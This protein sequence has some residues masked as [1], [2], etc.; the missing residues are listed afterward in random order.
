MSLK[1]IAP[2]AWF[3]LEYP[4][5]WHEFEDTE[6]S[7][8]FYNP[9]KWSG[10]FRISAYRGE[11]S[12]YAPDCMK[13]E[14][15]CVPGAKVVK[16]DSWECV[17]SSESFQ[18]NGSWYTTHIWLTGEGE[19]SVECSFTV[20]KGE[21]VR[22]AEQI[23]ASLCIRKKD[24]APLHEIIPV[25]VLEINAINEGFDWAVS[26][27]KKSLT[28]DFTS[29]TADIKNIQKVI[30]GDFLD[31]KQKQP[32]A[33]LGFAFCAILFNEIDGMEWVT[34]IDGL[35]EYPALRFAETNVMV[36]PDRLIWD[37]IKK[38]VTCN[39]KAEY[40][41]ICADVESVL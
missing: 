18:E 34:V 14:L 35:D 31:R 20:A 19:M 25:R 26:S 3:S 30:D 32:W 6:D 22:V 27:I 40:E 41:R 23:I 13:D 37:K 7:F 12:N 28:K 2:G 1:Y 36:Y 39:L 21:P 4:A 15:R 9:D 33:C 11:K 16:V 8:L 29:V 24:D 10:N 17:Y 5:G 38:G